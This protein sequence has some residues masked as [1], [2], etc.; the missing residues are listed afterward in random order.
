MRPLRKGL[1]KGFILR[2][3]SSA[4]TCSHNSSFQRFLFFF[5]FLYLEN[6]FELRDTREAA[7]LIECLLSTQSPGFGLCHHMRLGT[8][9][10]ISLVLRRQRQEDQNFKVFLHYIVSLRLA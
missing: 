7:Q 9:T 10:T 2:L 8:E 6:D 4:L 5:F 3:F 1:P